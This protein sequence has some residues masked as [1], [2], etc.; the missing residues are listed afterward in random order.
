[1]N[2]TRGNRKTML[3]TPALIG[4]LVI[5]LYSVC[6]VHTRALALYEEP[7]NNLGGAGDKRDVAGAVH[8]QVEAR[9]EYYAVVLTITNHELREFVFIPT[10]LA[11]DVKP[12]MPTW[13]PADVRFCIMQVV[14]DSVPPQREYLGHATSNLSI[15]DQPIQMI[16]LPASTTVRIEYRA[17]YDVHFSKAQIVGTKVYSGAF[18]VPV[19]DINDDRCRDLLQ[20]CRIDRSTDDRYVAEPHSGA[21]IILNA[22]S[23]GGRLSEADVFLLRGEEPA[24]GIHHIDTVRVDSTV[25]VMY[26]K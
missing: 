13:Y 20:R 26:Q 25:H 24:Q 7:T 10:F 23:V 1:M 12:F 9:S 8:V 3:L 15:S 17:R 18:D 14:L 2:P 22:S 21:W 6:A 4:M 11:V 5:A 16:R 19:W